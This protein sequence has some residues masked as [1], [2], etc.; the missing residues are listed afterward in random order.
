MLSLNNEESV[1]LMKDK[2]FVIFSFLKFCELE[3]YNEKTIFWK[4]SIN[5]N[6]IF[7]SNVTNI[8]Q[9]QKCKTGK[10][11]KILNSKKK[12]KN[13]YK[14][15]IMRKIIKTFSLKSV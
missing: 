14:R 11:L 9:Q 3:T 2:H 5:N 4:L 10:Q 8:I 6:V 12:K 7:Y 1:H 13:I 15:K